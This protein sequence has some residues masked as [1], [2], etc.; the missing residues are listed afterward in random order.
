MGELADNGALYVTR[1][2]ALAASLLKGACIS[3]LG[4]SD[5][6]QLEVV[7]DLA[8]DLKDYF[9]N[10]SHTNA[11]GVETTDLLAEAALRCADLAN[12]AACNV[13][14]F[15]KEHRPQAVAVVHLA[16]GTVKALNAMVEA[17]VS[18]EIPNT[19]H[20]SRDLRSAGWRAD[21]AVR[22]V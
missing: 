22:Q 19:G 11:E 3:A 10:L 6:L 9:D 14:Q 12:L 15:S 17:E 2:G 4:S 1:S 21:L 16:S 18:P 8:E 20:L 7:R 13:Y 5:S